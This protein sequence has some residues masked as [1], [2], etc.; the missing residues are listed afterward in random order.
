[1]FAAAS[2]YVGPAQSLLRIAAGLGYFSHAAAKLFGW[3]GGFGPN[4]E[5][6]E[7]M[8][9]FGTAGI[10]ETV[11]GTLLELGLFTR[12]AAFIASGEMAVAYFWIH[13]GGSGSPWWW[14]NRG[15]LVML[16][17]FIWLFFAAAGPGPWS[18]DARL[19]R[20]RGSGG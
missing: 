16:Y 14:E 7:L 10:I 3:F 5:P 18:L 8:S 1:M 11:A 15:E 20:S 4:G 19:A 9:R 2:R 13:W 12:P 17:C 6:A